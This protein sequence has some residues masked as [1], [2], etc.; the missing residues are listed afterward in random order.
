MAVHPLN[1]PVTSM[2]T[3]Q[4]TATV[5]GSSNQKVTWYVEGVKG[6]NNT[7]GTITAAGLYTPPA[8]FKTGQHYYI[9]AVSRAEPSVSG[10]AT[11]YLVSYAG[12]YTNKNDNNRSGQN[13][14]ETVLTPANVNVGSFGKLFSFPIDAPVSAQPLYVA[15][16]NMPSPLNGA[17]GYH[18]V[19]FVATVNDS[20]YA[21]DADGKVPAGPLWH[22]SFI[23]A[24]SVV[25]VP[26]TCLD[27]SGQWGI[28]PTPV[29][30]PTTNT[31]YVE[32]RTLEDTTSQCT[33]T[34][35]QRLHALDITTGD[36]KFGGPAVI[37]ASVPGTGEGSVSGTVSFDPRWENSRP[38]LLLS[39]SAQDQNSVVYMA[40]GSISDTE[41]YHGWVLGFDSQTLALKYTY[42]DTADGGGGGIWQMGAGL[43]ADSEGN[44]YVQTGNGTFDNV[45]DFG[46]SVLKLTQSNGSLILYDS[47]TPTNY[48]LLNQ[49]DWDISS[50]G[51]LLLPD[52]K[53]P[54]PHIMI[55]GGKDGNIY[56]MNRDNLGGYNE[57]NNNIL[58]YVTGQ[59]RPS[60][61]KT[62]PYYGIW[63]TASYFK[64]NVYIFGEYDYPKMFS[65]TKG[66]LSSEPTS[67]GTIQMR[68]P[69]PI[70][71]ANGTSNPIVWILQ[72]ETPALR[73]FAANDLTQEYYD[74]NQNP[75]RDS[76]GNTT[77]KRADPTV[78]NGRVYV[79]A[80]KFVYVYG[81]LQ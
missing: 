33:G 78:A 73:A 44:L 45:D 5:M 41:P 34:Y 39:Q 10:K 59:I 40:A 18:N 30:D 55:G 65:L 49:Q 8:T 56:V 42:N 15:N 58:Q 60:V 68:G 50:G 67:T 38:G 17:A 37:Q 54:Y 9:R 16:L 51:I 11:A 70:I 28:G 25:P 63:N 20:V 53:G 24:P 76:L 69:A 43:S 80:E 52:Q 79:P 46:S 77:V 64:N 61:P 31:I 12:L 2:V 72:F 23:D 4:F 13:T 57:K 1:A 7:V 19:V 35:V 22:D 47:F 14:E 75:S 6:G 74:T 32:V 66:V 21:Y 26:G 62:Q 29:I 81:L 71:S 48:E 36:E 3:Q 27:S